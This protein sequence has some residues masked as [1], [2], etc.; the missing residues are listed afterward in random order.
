MQVVRCGGG[1]VGGRRR[2]SVVVQTEEV[3]H[4]RGQRSVGVLASLKQR[5]LQMMRCEVQSLEQ[6]LRGKTFPYI[7]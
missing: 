2:L 1:R 4:V 3:A 6:K 5:K 7:C